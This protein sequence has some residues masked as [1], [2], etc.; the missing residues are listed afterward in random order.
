M[1]LCFEVNK[2]QVASSAKFVA[3][4]NGYRLLLGPTAAQLAVREPHSDRSR[5]LRMHLLN[6]DPAAE[7]R[8]V[9][10]LET[11]ANYFIGNDPS[12]W[13]TDVPTFAR[14]LCERVYPGVDMLYYGNQRQ[15]EYDFVVA[16]GA[17][18]ENIKLQFD[19]GKKVAVDKEGN[20]IVKAGEAELRHNR[21]VAFQERDGIRSEVPVGFDL[22]AD[23]VVGF[24]LGDYDRSRELVIDPVLVFSTYLGG[25][26]LDVGRAIFV[27]SAGNAYV[28][29]ESRSPDFTDGSADN[30]DV[31]VGTFTA[32]G[33]S[34]SYA[35]FGGSKD[36][37]ATG[38]AVDSDG[39]AYVSGS[40]QSD[41]LAGENSINPALSGPSDAF[42]AKLKPTIAGLSYL[43]LIGG[44]GSET[45][46]S[47]TIDDSG[48][49]YITGRTTSAD[50]PTVNALQS[51]YGG[52]DSD[53]FVSKITPVGSSLVYSTY[54][55]GSGSENSF[56]KS[57]IAIDATRNAYVTGDTNSTDFPLKDAIRSSNSD[58]HLDAYVSKIDPAGGALVY[59]TYLGGGNEDT[60]TGIAADA[61]GNAYISGSTKS[62]SFTGSGV[63]RP[64][65]STSDAYVAKLNS[66]GSA[67]SYL[68]FIGGPAGNEAAEAIAVDSSR[69]AYITGSTSLGVGT[70]GPLFPT[71]RPVQSY[72]AGKAIDVIVTRLSPT[73]VI[74]FST[75]LGGSGDETGLGIAVDSTGAIYV[76]GF[77]DSENFLT[78]EPLRS[79]N[80]GGVDL[81][82]AKINPD[83]DPNGPLIY[84]VVLVG[85]QM[86]VLGQNFAVG[87][88]IRLNDSPK[89]TN[90]GQ[91]PTEILV[92][93]KA[94]KKAKPG[95]TVQIQV[96]N[97]DGKKSNLF[98]F[99]KPE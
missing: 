15:L 70:A 58:L 76:T 7:I 94:G 48:N 71:V 19:G 11:R 59:S 24:Q 80:A 32:S 28:L 57:G 89:E 14:V 20:L 88:F 67:F 97:P 5:L 31:F 96:E 39:N 75:Y 93:K 98:F 27:S 52:G 69:N 86:R 4:G 10:P 2:G 22:L 63:T 34:F 36:E 56:E 73:G 8:G 61:A 65:G 26:L 37:I 17:D 45:G 16:P 72:F 44:S 9:D 21:P 55:G 1:P 40:T 90:G 38:L 91:D 47:I 82:V 46:V 99:T 84:N 33:G 13:H 64:A 18:P 54:L 77:T 43:T 23:G 78:A 12:K 3:G 68:T 42:V 66:A 83:A 41:N 50:F 85:K 92:S 49:A 62:T 60:G 53:A 74:N 95:R 81:F 51:G 6:A 35:F 25:S 87:A 30:A 79:E 29:G